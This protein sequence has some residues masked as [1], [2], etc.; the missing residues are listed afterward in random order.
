MADTAE[1]L[2]DLLR[3]RHPEATIMLVDEPGESPRFAAVLT[4]S[5]GEPVT[6]AGDD[7]AEALRGLLSEYGARVEHDPR[8]VLLRPD[9]GDESEG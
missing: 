1:Q 6:S 5:D 2:F 3:E 7:A 4:P 8:L 9:G